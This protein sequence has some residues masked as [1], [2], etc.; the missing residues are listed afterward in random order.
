MNTKTAQ[1]ERGVDIDT[2]S[3]FHMGVS[4]RYQ[5]KPS[6]DEYV[7]AHESEIQPYIRGVRDCIE[8]DGLVG[9]A[10]KNMA[11]DSAFVFEDGVRVTFSWRGWGDLMQA[12]VNKREGYL[13]YYM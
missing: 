6:W 5:G 8:R 1:L 10:A 9:S 7:A 12:V 11:D 2:E 3:P 4:S 13:A